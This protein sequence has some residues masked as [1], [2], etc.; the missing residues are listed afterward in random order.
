VLPAGECVMEVKLFGAAP[1]WLREMAAKFRLTRTPF[2]KYCSAVEMFDP[3][4]ARLVG[5][6]RAVA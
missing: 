4:F 5:G 2:S 3:V 6:R 1:Y